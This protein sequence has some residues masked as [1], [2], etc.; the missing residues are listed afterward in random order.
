MLLAEDRRLAGS[1]SG[2][3]I[4]RDLLR[5]GW[6]QTRH[7]LPVVVRYDATGEP[8]DSDSD[9]N[10]NNPNV[11]GSANANTWSGRGL[12][13][14]GIV[15]I[16]LE[17]IDRVT[18]LDPLAF[19]ERCVRA[20]RCGGLATV[21]RSTDDAVHIG[22]RATAIDGGDTES[23]GLPDGL[24]EALVADCREVALLGSPRP[25]RARREPRPTRPCRAHARTYVTAG[26]V[27][28][29]LVEAIS[30]P[31]RLFLFGGGDDA[32]PVA[33]LASSLGWEVLVCVPSLRVETRERFAHTDA[34]LV[35]TAMNGNDVAAW[36]RSSACPIAVV[37]GHDYDHDKAALALLLD[38]PARYIGVLGPRRRTAQMLAEIGHAGVEHDRRLHSPVGLAIGAETPAEIALAIVAEAQSA[39]AAQAWSH[40][41]RHEHEHERERERE[42]E[43]EHH[44]TMAPLHSSAP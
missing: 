11:N 37:M 19:I 2:G 15:E 17:R 43:R 22:S 29:V 34:T 30:P 23:S 6:W 5:R 21:F 33:E 14:N 4:E 31:T 9:V 18:K 40:D 36:V 32:V 35:P 44:E 25:P 7:G 24:R 20:Q 38:S 12:G 8:S 26:G 41:P 16:L 13:C 39:V 3:C 28:D 1:V 10:P 42:R 27:V